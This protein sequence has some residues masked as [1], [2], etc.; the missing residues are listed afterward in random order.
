M[1]KSNYTDESVMND[2]SYSGQF[3]VIPRDQMEEATRWLSQ[4]ITKE[5]VM[6]P[7]QVKRYQDKLDSLKDK[8][9]DSKRNEFNQL[10][11]E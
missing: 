4:K 11:K 8:L 3:R 6:R 2:P 9:S 1:S 7:D 10:S 5:S